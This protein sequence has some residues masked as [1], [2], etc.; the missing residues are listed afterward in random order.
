MPGERNSEIVC[1]ISNRREFSR[2][3][4]GMDLEEIVA[5]RVLLTYLARAVRGTADR[6]SV[7]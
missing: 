6:T 1:S 5:G 7:Q 2:I 4:S 3:E